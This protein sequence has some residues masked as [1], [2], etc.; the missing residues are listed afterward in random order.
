VFT[1]SQSVG[2]ETKEGFIHIWTTVASFLVLGWWQ[3][4]L[5]LLR[6]CLEEV[7]ITPAYA[8]NWKHTPSYLSHQKKKKNL[9]KVFCS[10]QP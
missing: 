3:G 9:T 7:T 6:P 4:I 2:V 1:G 10:H 5:K 8:V